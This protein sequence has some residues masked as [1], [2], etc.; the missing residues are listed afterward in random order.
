MYIFSDKLHWFVWKNY[1]IIV[2]ILKKKK[3]LLLLPS[4]FNGFFNGHFDQKMM[5]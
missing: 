2:K 3:V 5:T 1:N 4:G